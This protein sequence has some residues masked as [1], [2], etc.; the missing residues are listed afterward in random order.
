MAELEFP[1]RT[2]SKK[3]TYQV[4]LPQL[5]ALTSGESD[6]IANLANCIAALKQTFGFF[7]IGV[8]FV[9]ENNLVLGP[10]QGP[11]ACTRIGFGKG[12]CGT[13]WK[14]KK[15]IIVGDVSEFPGHISCNSA[16]KSEIV[17]PGF[18]NNEVFFVLDIDS[19]IINDFDMTDQTFLEE[20]IKNIEKML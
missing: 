13:A 18:K 7:W 14:E 4:L 3:D 12:V 10:F 17:V 1:G 5:K 8:Y 16:S 9:K 19:T 20:W 2:G 15:T 11:V 6:L